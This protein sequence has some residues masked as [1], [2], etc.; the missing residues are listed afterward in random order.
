MGP[1]VFRRN[2]VGN[3][4]G[5][6]EVQTAIQKGPLREF[7]RSGLTASGLNQG[8]HDLSL[9]ERGA[10]NVELDRV[11]A[12]VGAWSSKHQSQPFVQ[13]GI[14]GVA[15]TSKR[16][17][18][19]IHAVEGLGEHLGTKGQ[20]VGSRDANHRDATRARGGGDGTNRGSINCVA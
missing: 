13:Q 20:G 18:S 9:D 6:G 14:R 7:A 12:G 1:G 3:G 19:V 15:K 10:V 4:L 2:E 11:L 5:L 17:R 8:T 16:N